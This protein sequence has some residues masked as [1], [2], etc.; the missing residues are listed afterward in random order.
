MPKNGIQKLRR[1]RGERLPHCLPN[2]F[3]GFVHARAQMR[4]WTV[5]LERVW[6]E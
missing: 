4:V 1:S 2:F 6:A 5:E 3:G